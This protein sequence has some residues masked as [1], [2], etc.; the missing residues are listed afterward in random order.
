[1]PGADREPALVVCVRGERL[2]DPDRW[3]EAAA[4]LPAMAE[5]RQWQLPMTA[6]WKVKRM[7]IT[8]MLA[9][10]SHA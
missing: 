8:R 9:E 3:R 2:L 7:E 5:P 10:R 6:T 1:V 4:D